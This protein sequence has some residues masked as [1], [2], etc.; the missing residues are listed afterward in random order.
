M[1]VSIRYSDEALSIAHATITDSEEEISQEVHRPVI[2]SITIPFGKN[3]V[4]GEDEGHNGQ[5]S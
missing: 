2:S 3:E 4:Q 5:L 1:T